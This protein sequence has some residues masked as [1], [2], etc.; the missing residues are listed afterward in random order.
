MMQT[1]ESAGAFVRALTGWRRFPFAFGAGLLSALSFAPVGFFP[2]LL[3]GF[4]ALVLLIDGAVLH[5]K[6][7]R[8]AAFAGWA[9]S[10]GQFLA[11][12]YWVGYAFLVDAGQH[13]WQLPFVAL[14]FPGGLALFT[15]LACGVAGYLWRGGW[16]RIFLCGACYATGEWIRGNIFTGFPWDIPGYGW[17]ASL[18][19]LQ[20]VSV[21]G[22]YGLG[23]L[24]I[25]FGAS[26]A[27]LV[28]PR[29]WKIP[30][31]FA[32]LFILIW[33][34][35]AVRLGTEIGTVPGVRLRLVQPN[36]P[37]SEKYI[38]SLRDRHWRELVEL[39]LAKNGPAPTHIIWP[40]AAPPFL[41]ARAPHAL[42]DVTLLTARS[43]LMTGA[44]RRVDL[45]PGAEPIFFNSFYVFAHAGQLVAT[46]DKFHLVP[47]GEY[48]PPFLHALGLEKMVAIPGSFGFGDGPHTLD[49][50]GAPPMGPLI[51]YEILFPGEVTAQNR[52]QWLVNVTD[53]SWFGP[54][55]SSG[56]YQHLMI[57]RVRA[58]EEGLPIARDANTGISAV[59]DPM[60]RVLTKLAVD[61][62]GVVDSDLPRALP[63]TFFARFGE[64]IYIVLLFAAFALGLVPPLATRRG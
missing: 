16:Q 1:L 35:G 31:G 53:D 17:A 51:C 44:V 23:L 43:V 62:V 37:E 30:A 6:P 56:P 24:T 40:E 25:L 32:L 21:I 57:A 19:V 38:A 13:A 3:L 5:P 52:P 47:F 22:V 9:F 59:I 54:P 12:L 34:G 48:V 11:G 46:Y 50:P 15:A 10:F 4:G 60:G 27:L 29:A 20:S 41:L 36:V 63:E 64:T 55:S 58:I 7:V 45:Q 49:V 28:S 39:S 14:I 33:I 26:L 18:A 42:D 8:S 61:Q 2:F